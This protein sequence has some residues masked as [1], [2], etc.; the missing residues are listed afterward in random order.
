MFTLWII[1]RD[2][3]QRAALA[4]LAR[5]DDNAV[6][7]SPLDRH[8]E[9]A[10]EPGAVVL[11]VTGD[12]EQELEFVHRFGARLASTA[13]ILL[14]PAG[15]MEEARRL[16]D[17]LP[18]AY[19]NHP[20]DSLTLRRAIGRARARHHGEALSLRRGRERLRSRFAR[21]FADLEL[22]ELMRAVDPRLNRVPLLVRGE[23]GTGRTLL[24]RYVH[25]FGGSGEEA[26]VHVI[27]P[28]AEHAGDLLE[29]IVE[30][31]RDGGDESR[32]IWLEDADRM[33]LR[34][35]RKLQ[36]WIE[37]GLPDGVL[38]ASRLRW[39][40]GVG[41]ARD[42]DLEPG[43]D[44]RLAEALSGLSVSIP[45]LRERAGC[46]EPFVADTALKWCNAR[47]ERLRR[48]SP[49]AI[50][51][52]RRYPWP[53]N[54]HELEAVVIRTLSSSSVEQLLGAHLRFGGE[55][56]WQSEDSSGFA[57]EQREAE[58]PEAT[59]LDDEE[60][61]IEHEE[62]YDEE[63][64]AALEPIPVRGEIERPARAEPL[65]DAEQMAEQAAE[66]SLGEPLPA[67][68]PAAATGE[69]GES[70]AEPTR[71][72][73]ATPH[74]ERNLRRLV[75][76]VAH[77]VRNPL[78][79]IRTFSELLPEHYDDAEFRSHFRDLVTKDVQRIDEVVRRLQSVADL[80]EHKVEPVDMTALL[81]GLLDERSS[82]IQS[83][84]LLVLKELE[85]ESPHVLGD[86]IQLREGF[87]ALLDS[88]LAQVSDRGDVYL[89]SRYHPGGTGGRPGVR[90]L[91]RHT[92]P[93]DVQGSDADRPSRRDSSLDLILAET[94]IEA[95]S[96]RLTRDETD[97]HESI[98]IVDLPA[99]G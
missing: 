18:A 66:S 70:A 44:R 78:V 64:E 19:L 51:T 92:A 56:A 14:A 38:R 34:L 84:R 53:G 4:R 13:W 39:I 28:G 96:G 2:P 16:F 33:P 32:T 17:T 3:H 68:A 37:F 61:E 30:S 99:A 15:E 31:S 85:R 75:G 55:S 22:P 20:L 54:L 69:V 77:E 83:R 49:D 62:A 27:C 97:S 25:A 72:R 67:M 95:Q 98:L 80:S 82:Q 87:A 6:L 5:A 10:S 21:W 58:I 42:L 65:I 26:F 73:E 35:Q 7:G 9:S 23:E 11:G 1:H 79:S 29:Q 52:L 81:E 46:V 93:E 63:V 74:G 86:P 24:A 60:E 76:A 36:E 88:T 47:G 94:L 91:L 57:F 90:V 71:A 43:L 59:L 48:F 50:D 45:P 89:A 41:D 8:F 12:F 40:T